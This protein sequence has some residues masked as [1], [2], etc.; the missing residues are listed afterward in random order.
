MFED[1]RTE[2]F[3]NK[4]NKKMNNISQTSPLWTKLGVLLTLN[5]YIWRCF[6]IDKG[7]SCGENLKLAS[8]RTSQEGP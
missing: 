5:V 4:M 8:P 1:L 2:K 7:P 6:D 3:D